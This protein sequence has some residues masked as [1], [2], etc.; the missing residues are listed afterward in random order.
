M[1]A[2]DSL[3]YLLPCGLRDV[4]DPAFLVRAFSQWHAVDRRIHLCIIGPPLDP[5]VRALTTAVGCLPSA[6]AGAGDAD[7]DAWYDATV[8]RQP[9]CRHPCNTSRAQQSG[10]GGN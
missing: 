1:H 4:K 5:Q 10:K 3:L 8:R 7:A 9:V 2:P 6:R